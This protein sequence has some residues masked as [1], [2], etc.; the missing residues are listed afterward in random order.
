[1]FRWPVTPAVERAATLAAIIG[2]A[3]NA[4]HR[5]AALQYGNKGTLA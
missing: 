1:M 2:N 4:S 5:T 3:R